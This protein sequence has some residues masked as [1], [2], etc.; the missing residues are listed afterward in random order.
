MMGDRADII[1]AEPSEIS[2]FIAAKCE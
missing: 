2:P 1:F